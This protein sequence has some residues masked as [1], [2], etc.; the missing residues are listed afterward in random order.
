[1]KTAARNLKHG[2]SRVLGKINVL[3]Y[4]LNESREGFCRHYPGGPAVNILVS[5]LGNPSQIS[6]PPKV[7]GDQTVMRSVFHFR[8]SSTTSKLINTG[9]ISVLS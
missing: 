2:R 4:D 8:F 3:R 9:H 1:M 5:I 7:K 6:I